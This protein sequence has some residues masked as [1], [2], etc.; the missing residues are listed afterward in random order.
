[1]QEKG[2]KIFQRYAKR[3]EKAVNTETIIF[4]VVRLGEHIIFGVG[5]EKLGFCMES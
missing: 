2:A 1:M 3:N 4:C 5:R